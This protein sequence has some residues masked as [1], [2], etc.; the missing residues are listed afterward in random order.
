M[1][2]GSPASRVGLQSRDIILTING[3]EVESVG[4]LRQL[5]GRP[6]ADRRWRL[7]IRRGDKVFDTVVE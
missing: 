4:R 6:A 1:A 7:A 5:L 2:R 3:A